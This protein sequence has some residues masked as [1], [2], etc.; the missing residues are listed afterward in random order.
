MG[1]HQVFRP[2]RGVGVQVSTHVL[3]LQLQL[4]LGALVGAL[5]TVVRG[6]PCELGSMRSNLEGKVLE[7]VRSA[8]GL[9]SL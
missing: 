8:V 3:N 2:Y 9:V 6:I 7:E 5:E 4:V 1:W